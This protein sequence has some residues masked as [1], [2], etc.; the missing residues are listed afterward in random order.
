MILVKKLKSR[1]CSDL[2]VDI[3]DDGAMP[4]VVTSLFYPNGDSVN[5]YFREVGRNVV[6]SDEGTTFDTLNH[7]GVEITEERKGIIESICRQEEVQL[8]STGH[9][10]KPLRAK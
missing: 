2:V 7:G 6:V 8:S 4:C 9:I 5:L 1:L 3:S 10:S